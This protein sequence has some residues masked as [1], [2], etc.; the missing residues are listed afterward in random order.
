MAWL[1]LAGLPVVP[2]LRFA[3]AI[4]LTSSK[5]YGPEFRAVWPAILWLYL[6]QCAGQ[7]VGFVAGPG[8]SPRR[9]Q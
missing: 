9:V 7:I 6:V 3:R 2:Y 5:G 8:D 4:A 1:R